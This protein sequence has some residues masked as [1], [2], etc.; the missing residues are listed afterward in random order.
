MEGGEH[1]LAPLGELH[2]SLVELLHLRQ[3]A[4]QLLGPGGGEECQKD[5]RISVSLLT[6]T[7][8][9]NHDNN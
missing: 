6:N 2:Q 7:E 9:F 3:V 8:L 5:V 1:A 4:L